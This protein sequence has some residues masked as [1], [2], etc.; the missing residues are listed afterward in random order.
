[1]EWNRQKKADHVDKLN[2]REA[3]RGTLTSTLSST[4]KEGEAAEG[5]AKADEDDA[6]TELKEKEVALRD[7]DTLGAKAGLCVTC[8]TTQGRGSNV[9]DYMNPFS[10]TTQDINLRRCIN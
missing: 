10:L 9:D 5:Q 7:D 8:S 4:S 6:L 1:M 2:G 3:F